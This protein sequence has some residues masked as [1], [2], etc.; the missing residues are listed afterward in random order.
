MRKTPRYTP[1]S[2]S[3]SP[4]QGI[5]IFLFSLCKFLFTLDLFYFYSIIAT[6]PHFI[7][8]FVSLFVNMLFIRSGY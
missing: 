7:V 2:R 1:Y 5:I 8:L 3:P 6:I 4:G